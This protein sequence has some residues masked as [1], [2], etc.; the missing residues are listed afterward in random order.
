MD[1]EKATLTKIIMIRQI[2]VATI[3]G[4]TG[5]VCMKNQCKMMKIVCHYSFIEE[6]KW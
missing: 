2:I 4:I 3:I 6:E 5:V 1:Q